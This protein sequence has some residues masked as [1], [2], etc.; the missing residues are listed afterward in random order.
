MRDYGIK[1]NISGGPWDKIKNITGC[2]VLA[3]IKKDVK[4]LQFW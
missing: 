3:D 4:G 2:A 1:Q